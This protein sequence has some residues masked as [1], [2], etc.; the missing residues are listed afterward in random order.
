MFC[1]YGEKT[2]DEDYLVSEGDPYTIL[3]A[4]ECNARL[5]S[6]GLKANF[7]VGVSK[8]QLCLNQCPNKRLAYRDKSNDQISLL[9]FISSCSEEPS[10]GVYNRV[11]PVI[12][13]IENIVWPKEDID[14]ERV[15]DQLQTAVNETTEFDY[16]DIFPIPI[17]PSTT[18]RISYKSEES[19]S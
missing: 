3:S 11:E 14:L 13:W 18:D 17:P 10:I 5:I 4:S 15:I 12:S 19:Y 7:P 1:L 8:H 9:G 6:S 2:F 16:D